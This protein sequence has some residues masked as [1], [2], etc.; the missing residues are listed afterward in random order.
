MF[1]LFLTKYAFIEIN[2]SSIINDF[3]IL[4][5]EMPTFETKNLNQIWVS[6]KGAWRRTG[7]EDEWHCKE[8]WQGINKT[9]AS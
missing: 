7:I 8:S 4:S 6:Y 5:L 9:W 2:V 1:S 3:I